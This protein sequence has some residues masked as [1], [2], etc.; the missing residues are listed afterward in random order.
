MQRKENPTLGLVIPCFNEQAVLPKLF[1]ELA[2]FAKT[3]PGPVFFLFVNDGSRDATAEMLDAACAKNA[4]FA[5]VH[6]SRN[7]GHQTAVSAGLQNVR[8][9]VVAVI[10]A[11]LQDP[12]AVI[13]DMIAKWREDS[14]VVYGVR[15]N[16][17]EG[18]LL[19]AA[20][21]GFYRLLKRVSNVEI[22][23][24]AGDFCLMDRAVVDLINAMPEHNRFIRG[25]RGWVGFKQ[26]GLPY[27][28]SAR[29]AGE[30]KYSISKLL[31][32]AL[33]GIINFS[34]APLRLASWIGMLSAA[35]GVIFFGYA[36]VSKFFLAKTPQ[37]WA[38]LAAIVVF[39]GG[40]QLLVLGIIGEYLV[41]IFD[42]AKNRPHYVVAGK[43]GW[44]F[45]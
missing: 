5:C 4:Q 39:F 23:L 31:N 14:D 8:G 40:M 26:T 20:Y 35:S 45:R 1:D 29:A 42:E 25:M 21:A 11:D 43:S 9:D 2:A 3:A 33:D 44:L 10:D 38:S 17:K 13:L 16:R 27:D 6:F 7:F 37:G 32:L 28:R 24:D 34:S 22:P 15:K 19:R 30:T 36:L 12:P 18:L 41:R